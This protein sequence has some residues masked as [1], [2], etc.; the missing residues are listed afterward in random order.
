M[1]H[2]VLNLER[3]AGLLT[4]VRNHGLEGR[5]PPTRAEDV[6]VTR[7]CTPGDAIVVLEPMSLREGNDEVLREESLAHQYLAQHRRAKNADVDVFGLQRRYLFRRREVAQLDLHVGMPLCE[8][9]DDACAVEKVRPQGATHE[10]L[11]ELSA[12]RALSIPRRLLRLR[13]E[14]PRFTQEY[15]AGV[16]Q[17]HVTLRPVKQGG[18][19]LPLEATDLLAQRRLRDMEP[20]SGSPEM[21][22]FGHGEEVAQVAQLHMA[23]HIINVSIV[24]GK[25]IGR[26]P[27]PIASWNCSSSVLHGGTVHAPF[28]VVLDNPQHPHEPRGPIPGCPRSKE[29]SMTGTL[30]TLL[31]LAVIVGAAVVVASYVS[32]RRK[33]T[34]EAIIL[35]SQL[36]DAIAR[37][38][39]L[40]GLR[41]T[42]N[43]R[44]S[45]WRSSQVTIE[46]AGEVPTPELRERVMRMV[47]AEAWRLR[48]EV[49][50]VDHLFI[51][52]PR[53]VPDSVAP[54]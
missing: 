10:E 6:G 21:E 42:P 49:Q 9:S 54:R 25:Y 3:Q 7:E 13:D 4:C 12:A 17:L 2:L 23:T 19:Q 30:L 37:E 31:F 46:V 34:E 29:D 48:P 15:S 53:R 44:V 45:G 43:A 40:H 38:T 51:V 26:P 35:Q 50:T 16:R 8:E 14:G 41:I 52:P 24:Q 22:L 33:R 47:S 27:S 28:A 39:M 32:K 5:C 11:T 20:R 18:V 1:L 36:S